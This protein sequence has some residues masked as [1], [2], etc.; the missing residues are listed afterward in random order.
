MNPNLDSL[1]C[2][3]CG[4]PDD[5]ADDTIITRCE[6]HRGPSLTPEQQAAADALYAAYD[7]YFTEVFSA[8]GVRERMLAVTREP[9]HLDG[10]VIAGAVQETLPKLRAYINEELARRGLSP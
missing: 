4:A 6:A 9:A 10:V 1:P 5:G 7:R 8:P 2:G 3:I